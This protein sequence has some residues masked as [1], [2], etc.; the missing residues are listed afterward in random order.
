MRGPA[1]YVM[2]YRLAVFIYKRLF[3]L[4]AP[5]LV[6]SN[7]NDGTN[8]TLNSNATLA[9]GSEERIS[10]LVTQVNNL[11]VSEKSTAEM[12]RSKFASLQRDFQELMPML[13]YAIAARRLHNRCDLVTFR[14]V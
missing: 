6:T 3:R 7:M 1:P 5:G 11:L 12:L 2:H 9:C 10:G 8:W 14:G 13:E 4:T